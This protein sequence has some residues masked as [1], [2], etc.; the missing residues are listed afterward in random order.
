MGKDSK[1][2]NERPFVS[3]CTPTYNRRPFFPA[4][5]ECVKHQD[6]PKDR[7]EWIIIDDGTDKIEDLV[8]NIP[9]VKYFKYGQQMVLGKKRNISNEK[10]K[11]DIIVYMDDDDYYPPT[12]V[13]HAVHMLKLHPSILCAGAS[14]QLIYFKHIQKMYQLGPYRNNH[15]TAGTLAFRRE[16]LAM[17]SF[18]NDAALAEEK[19]FLKNFT[20]PV[21][22]LDFKQTSV[23]F[24]HPHNTFDKKKLL[25]NANPKYI[26][27][28]NI[29]LET[30]ITSKQL[31]DF[32]C[33]QIDDLLRNYT[34][35]AP[36]MKPE[37]LRQQQ[38]MQN[39]RKKK[40]LEQ[41]RLEQQRREQRHQVR[42]Q[43][44]QQAQ[45]HL[46]QRTHTAPH[47]MLRDKYG[48]HKPFI[49]NDILEVLN[50]RERTINELVQTIKQKD[51]HIEYLKQQIKGLK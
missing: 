21:V 25:V 30:I 39:N 35:G 27:K 51:L 34:A 10:A 15:A 7:L 2:S 45:Q 37:V 48:N 1:K 32:Y 36:N 40:Y 11:G 3:I 20:I 13:S 43:Q 8:C 9:Q 31:Y 47:Y 24:S 38:A 49:T 4:I 28:S 50:V 5:I 6:Y 16:L 26:K 18:Q 22:Q 17:T 41:R 12:R 29:R 19:Y 33:K 14:K 46:E 42:Q 44:A 23:M